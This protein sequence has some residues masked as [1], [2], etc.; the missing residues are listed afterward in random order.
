LAVGRVLSRG[1]LLPLPSK[2]ERCGLVA[3]ILLE[4][5]SGCL[6]P[7]AHYAERENE[8]GQDHGTDY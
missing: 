8:S 1:A 3:E 6:V 2:H 5:E 7:G 4:F